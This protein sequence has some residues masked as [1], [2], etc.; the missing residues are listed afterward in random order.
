M[1]N[2]YRNVKETAK[3]WGITPRRLQILCAEGRI[4]G[5]SKLGRE[6]AIS[7]NAVKPEDRRIVNGQYKNWRKS[8]RE[9]KNR[10]GD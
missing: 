6:W 9:S 8:T 7:I 5:A 1:I 10:I 4:E 3:L 2:G